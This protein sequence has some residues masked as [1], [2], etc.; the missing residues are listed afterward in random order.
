MAYSWLTCGY[1]FYGVAQ[2][3]SHLSGNVF[4]NVAASALCTTLGTLLSIGLLR[5]MGRRN[6]IVIC[7]TICVV[8][9]IMLA[10]TPHGTLPVICACL[11]IVSEFIVFIVVYLFTSEMFPTVVRNAA[12]GFSSMSARIGSMISPFVIDLGSIE[13]HLPPIV[14]AIV[15]AVAMFV[16]FLMPETKDCALLTTLQE[17]EEFKSKTRSTASNR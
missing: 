12:M 7:H 13:S 4:M 14:F 10:I 16:T 17:G 6:I 2:Y 5:I 1:C 3:I 15:P 9:F 8:C 11:G